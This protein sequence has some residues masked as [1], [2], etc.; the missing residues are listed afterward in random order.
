MNYLDSLLCSNPLLL[1]LALLPR[2]TSQI[3][4]QLIRQPLQHELLI[5]RD[6]RHD[7][8]LLSQPTGPSSP[9]HVRIAP[10][11]VRQVEID[12]V[13]N[14]R[15]VE[16]AGRQ[17]RGQHDSKLAIV[18]VVPVVS[19]SVSVP[20][21]VDVGAVVR[22]RLPPALGRTAK[23]LHRRGARPRRLLQP[24]H[25]YHGVVSVPLPGRVSLLPH[26]PVPVL[27]QHGRQGFQRPS[28]IAEYQYLVVVVHSSIRRR[29]RFR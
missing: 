3:Q 18:G 1:L 13:R 20:L 21:R 22:P 28:W 10:V 17:V 6:Q 26:D 14:S 16:A 15:Y 2:H 24:Q 8:P 7:L 27:G 25:R 12:H 11:I 29:R 19:A 4:R 9:V 5:R 23:S